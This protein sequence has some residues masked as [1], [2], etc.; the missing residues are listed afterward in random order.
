MADV[1]ARARPWLRHLLALAGLALCLLFAGLSRWQYGRGEDK[2][3]WLERVEQARTAPPR[4]LDAALADP[5]LA[6]LPVTVTADIELRPTPRLRLD[7]QQREG[8]VGLREYALARIAGS[9]AAWLIVDLGWQPLPPDRQLPPL[10]ALPARL[11]AL[12]LLTDVPGQGL[13]LAPNPPLGPDSDS[14]LLNYLDVDE[15]GA[16]TG[17]DIAPRLLRL[18]P[19]MPVGHARDLD[20][21]PN[22]LPPEKHRGYALQWAG[23]SLAALIITLLLYFRSRR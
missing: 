17:L 15:L 18:D 10:Q 8:R 6:G 22:T 9:E 1:S 5:A 19:A 4:A 12:G 7:N 21:L 3:L 2:A 16:Q 13:R 23:L 14:A 11:K 20:V